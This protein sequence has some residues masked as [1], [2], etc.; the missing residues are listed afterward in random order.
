[1]TKS[2]R[3]WRSEK[4]E[5]LDDEEHEEKEDKKIEVSVRPSLFGLNPIHYK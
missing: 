5:R 4:I 3:S 2:C 1:M